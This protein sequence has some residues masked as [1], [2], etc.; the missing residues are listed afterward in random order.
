MIWPLLGTRRCTVW[1]HQ[2]TVDAQ[3]DPCAR[4]RDA[5]GQFVSADDDDSVAV[6]GAI[7]LDRAG[8]GAGGRRVDRVGCGACAAGSGAAASKAFEIGGG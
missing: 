1:G 4:C 7:D 3:G 5:D 8:A 2:F 6:G